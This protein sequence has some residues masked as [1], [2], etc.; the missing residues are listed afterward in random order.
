MICA[1]VACQAVRYFA[2]ACLALV[3]DVTVV[4]VAIAFGLHVVPARA[5]GLAVGLT[6]TYLC[7]VWFVFRPRPPLSLG[8]F[9]RYVAGQSAGTAVNY[10][11]STVLLALAAGDRLLGILAV[12][13][14]AGVGFVLNFLAARRTLRAR[15]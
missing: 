3:L 10:G 7:S 13:V 1:P 5:L 11:V 2:G 4:T 14:G 8:G 12:G 6:T 15:F 9:T